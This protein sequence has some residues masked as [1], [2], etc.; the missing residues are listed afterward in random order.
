MSEDEWE[1]GMEE[2]G[3]NRDKDVFAQETH[4]EGWMEI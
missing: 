4:G 2:R 3:W 1:V